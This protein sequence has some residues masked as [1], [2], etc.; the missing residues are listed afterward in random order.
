MEWR[1]L[2]ED[3]GE[4]VESVGRRWPRADPAELLAIKGD[5]ERFERYIS[6]THDL[7]RSEVREDIEALLSG[8]LSAVPA[9]VGPKDG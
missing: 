5:R 8:E 2:A 9:L 7:T 1:Q 6:A 3:W 4:F